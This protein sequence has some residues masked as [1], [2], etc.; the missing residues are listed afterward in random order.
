MRRKLGLGCIIV[1]AVVTLGLAK[2][3]YSSGRAPSPQ[4]ATV[5]NHADLLLSSLSSYK[6]WTLV[7]TVPQLMEPPVAADCARVVGRTEESPHTHKYISVYVN[8][9]GRAA[10]MTQ[11]VP[12]FPTG[13]IIVKEKLSGKNSQTPELLTAMVKREKGYNPDSGDWEYVVLDGSASEIK[14]RGTLASCNICH[15][16]YKHSDFVTR[17]YLPR[18]LI[19]KLK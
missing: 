2:F 14:E 15:L 12:S 6:K 16:N 4:P 9:T 3:E 7:N 5:V 1:M 17:T 8:E 19:L 10:M 13:S 11:L 18:E